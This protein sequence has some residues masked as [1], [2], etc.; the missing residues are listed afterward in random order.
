MPFQCN[1]WA[2]IAGA[3]QEPAFACVFVH[4]CLVMYV[5]RDGILSQR[6]ASLIASIYHRDDSEEEPANE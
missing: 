2:A 4:V 3:V 1:A 5:S 6:R